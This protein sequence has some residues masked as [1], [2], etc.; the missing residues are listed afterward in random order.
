MQ[1]TNRDSF[2]TGSRHE[3]ISRP[4]SVHQL[5]CRAKLLRHGS[6]SHF[7]W[8]YYFSGCSEGATG[9]G[10]LA[11]VATKGRVQAAPQV[12]AAL[13]R[14]MQRLAA[15]STRASHRAVIWFTRATAAIARIRRTE[16]SRWTSDATHPISAKRSLDQSK[17]PCSCLIALYPRLQCFN[18]EPKPTP[19]PKHQPC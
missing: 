4:V 3:V 14:M 10:E 17:T 11:I 16:V 13:P 7:Q 19:G 2:G 8:I 6:G 12:T 9:R 5:V 18:R 15:P 1:Q